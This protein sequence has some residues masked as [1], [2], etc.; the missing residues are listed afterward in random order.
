MVASS[1]SASARLPRTVVDAIEPTARVRVRADEHAQ[2]EGARTSL[3]DRP[4]H[5]TIVARSQRARVMGKA[6]GHDGQRSA[7]RTRRRHAADLRSLGAD[8]G[9]RT[10]DPHLGKVMDLVRRLGSTPLSSFCPPA[11][12]PVRRVGPSPG[13]VQRVKPLPTPRWSQI[14]GDSIAAMAWGAVEL[15]PEVTNWLDTLTDD[16]FG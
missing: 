1:R 2:L 16:E 4:L 13:Y 7:R 11:F 5:R 12:R 8:D 14:A 9:I 15:E 3:T 10:R 6:D